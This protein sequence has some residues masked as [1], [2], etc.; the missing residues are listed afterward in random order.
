MITG[1]EFCTPKVDSRELSF[2]DG[3]RIKGSFFAIGGVV[4]AVR[5]V[6]QASI[7]LHA[8]TRTIGIL[9][10]MASRSPLDAPSHTTVRNWI[11]R[12]G[13]YVLR[14]VAKQLDWIWIADHSYSIGTQKVLVVLG[15]RLEV[16]LS[17]NR[18]LQHTD[19]TV[20]DLRSVEHSNGKVVQ[21]Q[22]ESLA[23]RCGEP[24]AIL[25]DAGSDLS[26]GTSGFQAKHPDVVDMY[27]VVHMV[28][29][30]IEKIMNAHPQWAAFRKD[31]CSCANTIRQS[32]LAHLKP[33]CP[34]T[35]AR[36]MSFNR[37][38]CW[39][40][41]ALWVLDRVKSGNL[42][43]RQKERLPYAQV[44]EKLRWL[45]QYRHTLK[46]WEQLSLIGRQV[47]AVVRANGYGI[48]TIPALEA[49]KQT[50]NN[51]ACR[52]FIDDVIV[53]ITPTCE[54]AARHTRLPASSEVIESLFGKGKHLLGGGKAP[55]N[56][57]S[58]FILSMV[59]CTASITQELVTAALANI[60]QTMVERWET[61]N[62]RRS[63]HHARRIDLTPTPK[64]QNLRKPMP[65]PIANY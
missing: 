50:I 32:K 16:Y 41:R 42:A 23:E 22:F 10:E 7:S 28:S 59:A 52:K 9:N 1:S 3:G 39:G 44:N 17:L 51:R 5:I 35:K 14:N 45:R 8:A 56:S 30:K 36:Y 20:L 6:L 37:E 43:D 60:K 33:P 64:E 4:T 11:L 55:T 47:I 61:E 34:R 54:L 65:V 15:I 19:V 26:N 2:L 46:Q 38:V 53:T 24:L 25:R 12:V 48:A 58:G 57:F 62:F 13:L 63:A 31:C 40:A 21:S 29:R 49:I 18:P 27:D